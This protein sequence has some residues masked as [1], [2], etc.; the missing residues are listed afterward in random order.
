M[1]NCGKLIEPKVIKILSCRRACKM[2]PKIRERLLVCKM[3][4][5]IIKARGEDYRISAFGADLALWQTNNKL[6]RKDIHKIVIKSPLGIVGY[7]SLA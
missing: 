6:T 1:A 5:V 2:H 3:L 7:K 4:V